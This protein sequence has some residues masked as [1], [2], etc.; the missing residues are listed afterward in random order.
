MRH[1]QS[2]FTLAELAVSLSLIMVLAIV[3]YPTLITNVGDDKI[4]GVSKGGAVDIAQ[5]FSNYQRENPVAAG[6][7]ST[8]ILSYYGNYVRVINNGTANLQLENVINKGC[9][10]LSPCAYTSPCDATTPCYV[11]NNGALLQYDPAASFGGMTPNQHALRFVLDPDNTGPQVATIF[12]LY[13]TG[14]VTTL[15]NATA[16][17]TYADLLPT[18]NADPSY[19]ASW[20]SG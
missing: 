17:T 5:S 12:V 20:I 7:L 19:V 18:N 15:G 11:L 9:S 3:L 14:R 6:T 8:D 4:I 10:V 16:G 13:S 1:Y 2:G